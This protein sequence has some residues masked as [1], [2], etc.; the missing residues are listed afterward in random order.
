MGNVIFALLITGCFAGIAWSL[1]CL[2]RNEKVLQFRQR[3]ISDISKVSRE[4]IY[5]GD[6]DYEWRYDE[7]NTVP[8]NKMVSSFKPLTVEAWY[9]RNPARRER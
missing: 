9:P 8:Y 7:F 5:A 2:N 6:Y 4:A 1:Y 3:I